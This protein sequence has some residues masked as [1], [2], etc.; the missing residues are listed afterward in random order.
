MAIDI[1]TKWVDL[2]KTLLE[3]YTSSHKFIFNFGKTRL[4]FSAIMLN[5]ISY[6]NKPCCF[7]EIAQKREHISLG[8]YISACGH[9][10]HLFVIY[11][12]K[13]LPLLLSELYNFFTIFGINVGFMDEV[14]C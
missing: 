13:Q 4:D 7:V 1:I 10:F 2:L 8:P 9:F 12:L 6:S 5:V 3:K 14:F 11:L